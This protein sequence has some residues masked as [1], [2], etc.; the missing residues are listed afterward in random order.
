MQTPEYNENERQAAPAP[1]AEGEAQADVQPAEEHETGLPTEHPSVPSNTEA[2][3]ARPVT[4]TAAEVS[5]ERPAPEIKSSVLAWLDNFWYHY[6][7]HTLIALFLAVVLIVGVAQMC[8]KNKYDVFIMYAGIHDV[9]RKS[10]TGVSEYETLLQ[11]LK[12][13]SKDYDGDGE[14]SVS[15]LPLFLPS[16]AEIEELNKQ[17]GV[18]VN[19][20]VVADNVE[21]FNTNI[22]Y[23]NYYLCFLSTT[24]YENYKNTA[25]VNIFVPLGDYVNGTDAELYA[26][27]AIL[28]S[29]T[30]FGKS[31]GFSAFPEDTVIC[32]RIHS[33]VAANL[34]GSSAE[35]YKNAENVLRALLAY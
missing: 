22:V 12:K 7:W 3:P 31:A 4:D 21:I 14:V 6:K 13:I 17:D 23:S 19:T 16:A 32:L 28:L 29:S 11:G 26:P 24:V 8:R 10:T 1:R 5:P 15:F 34:T 2:P 25:G 20:A 27:D 30:D 18:E 33:E 35:H 9:E